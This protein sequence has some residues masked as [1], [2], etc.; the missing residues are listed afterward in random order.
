MD[1]A[2]RNLAG[3]SRTQA[4]IR[5]PWRSDSLKLNPAI[6]IVQ[7]LILCL[8]SVAAASSRTAR[9][10][11]SLNYRLEERCYSQRQASVSAIQRFPHTGFLLSRDLCHEAIA[12][13]QAI[14]GGM[15]NPDSS[16]SP[17][18]DLQAFSCR[19]ILCQP[20]VVSLPNVIAIYRHSLIEDIYW[21]ARQAADGQRKLFQPRNV[22]IDDAGV[23]RLF[24][25]WT[26]DYNCPFLKERVGEIGDGGKW[27][28]E[29]L[30]AS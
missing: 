9:D 24:D 4:S 5:G 19:V 2:L 6:M 10:T 7:I 28:R 27:V 29:L 15:T 30:Q 20:S 8:L 3:S 17:V 16:C 1:K 21:D 11:H 25:L 12:T 18:L 23:R 26:P 22:T 13:S 14:L